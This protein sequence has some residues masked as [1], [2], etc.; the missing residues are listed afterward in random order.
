MIELTIREG[1][2]STRN[3]NQA[4][5]T[6]PMNFRAVYESSNKYGGSK[7]LVKLKRSLN[8]WYTGIVI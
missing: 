2:E 5:E 7:F 1:L 6:A 3:L 8:C 4:I